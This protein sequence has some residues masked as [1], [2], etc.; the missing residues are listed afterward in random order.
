M[1]DKSAEPHPSVARV[2]DFSR[3]VWVDLRELYRAGAGSTRERA[4]L[5]VQAE[6]ITLDQRAP[7]VLHAWM[8]STRGDWLGWVSYVVDGGSAFGPL[9]MRHLVPRTALSPR[10]PEET[11]EE[12]F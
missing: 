1:F 2:Y 3:P 5:R 4:S 11:D 10:R 8:R 12:P 9:R 7:G 6:G